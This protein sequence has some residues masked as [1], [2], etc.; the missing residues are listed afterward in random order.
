MKKLQFLRE[1]EQGTG[2]YG[3]TEFSDMEEQEFR[4]SRYQL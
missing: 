4:D 3:I 1:T 2:R